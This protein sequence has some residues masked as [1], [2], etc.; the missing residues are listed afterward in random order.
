MSNVEVMNDDMDTFSI[1]KKRE[2]ERERERHGCLVL[3]VQAQLAK[4]LP[5]NGNE[6]VKVKRVDLVRACPLWEREDI[7]V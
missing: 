4:V 3:M 1:F 7:K 5:S 6:I 2:R